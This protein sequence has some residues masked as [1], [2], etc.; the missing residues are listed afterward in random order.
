MGAALDSG[1]EITT[2]TAGDFLEAERQLMA[3]LEEA[4]ASAEELRELAQAAIKLQEIASGTRPAINR[5]AEKSLLR[6]DAEKTLRILDDRLRK[7]DPARFSQGVAKAKQN[8]S[9]GLSATRLFATRDAA[10]EAARETLTKTGEPSEIMR[11][12][13][14]TDPRAYQRRQFFRSLIKTKDPQLAEEVNQ[15][16]INDYVPAL[17]DIVRNYKSS[18]PE[19]S[20]KS[21]TYLIVFFLG[22]RRA[23]N[24]FRDL[25][26][27]ELDVFKP[28]HIVDLQHLMLHEPN[29]EQRS[30]LQNMLEILRSSR[31]DLFEK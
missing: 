22:T 1:L 8:H 16:K 28:S 7:I 23:N 9:F 3:G 30:Y 26:S 18:N 2:A 25:V 15:R 21:L 27:T 31:P 20:A 17:L 4:G 5:E 29:E 24:A 10:L 14:T 11:L 13:L 12:A 19:L 6:Y